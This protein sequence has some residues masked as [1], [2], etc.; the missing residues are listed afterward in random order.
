[1]KHPI[2]AVVGSSNTDLVW[3]GTRLPR[4]G[5]SLIG[6][7]FARHAG[8][9]GANQ[10]VAAARAGARV[11]FI[12]ARGDDDFGAE[13]EAGLRREGVNT[14]HF[15]VKQGETSGVALI[16]IGGRGRQNMIGVAPSANRRLTA[17]DVRAAESDLRRADII[18]TVL[19]IPLPAVEATAEIAAKAGIPF[20]LTPAPVPD[21][22]LPA[23]LLRRVSVMIPNEMEAQRLTGR[24]GARAAAAALQRATGGQVVVTLGGR[25]ALLVGP[26]G[27]QR[28]PAPRVQPMDTVGA[29]DCFAGWLAVSLAEGLPSAAA[30]ERAVRAASISVTRHGAQA[31][32]PRREEVLQE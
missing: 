18:V 9:K 5:E 20:V 32:M 12:G 4:P 26:D 2:I 29:G 21:R 25:G 31:A 19:E 6:E 11:L 10:A 24:R 28:V 14:R 1:M 22:P 15:V 3:Y 30:V 17:E 23:R 16:F 8:G 7:R 13:A 27:T